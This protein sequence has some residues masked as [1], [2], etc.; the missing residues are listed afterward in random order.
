M[1]VLVVDIGGS[2]VKV[3]VTGQTEPRRFDSGP[4]LTPQ[5][6]VRGVQEIARDWSYEIISIGYPGPVLRNIP[7][8][9]PHNLGRGWVGFNFEAAFRCPVKLI[10]DAAVQALGSYKG[11]KMLFLGLGTGLGS[12]MIVDGIIE[13]MELGHL[14][15]KSRIYEH[16]VGQRGLDRWGKHKWRRHVADVVAYFIAA[17]E[18]DDVVLGGG[19]ARLLKT[20][21]PNCRAGNN[22][23]AFLGGFRLWE[24]HSNRIKTALKHFKNHKKERKYGNRSRTTRESPA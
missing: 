12:T 24:K 2:H 1:N 7:I 4:K 3:L 21:P 16:Y 14:P 11:G 18:P 10:N 13:P 6:M 15:Y 9:E 19:N 8:S 5:R 20:L 17:L 23:N 22:A